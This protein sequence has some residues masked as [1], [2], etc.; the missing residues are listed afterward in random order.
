MRRTVVAVC[1]LAASGTAMNP[2]ANTRMTVR[3]SATESFR[4][5]IELNAYHIRRLG[6]TS[7]ARLLLLST[8]G[9][10]LVL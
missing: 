10:R 3:R 2:A 9:R 8:R 4:R 5:E 7:P 1:A 6:M